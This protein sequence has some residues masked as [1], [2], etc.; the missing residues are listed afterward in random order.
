MQKIAV[1][2]ALAAN[3]LAV[4]LVF[5][6]HGETVEFELAQNTVATELAKRLPL[7]LEFSD[8][9]NKE[10]ITP[11]NE[12]LN[13]KMTAKQ[14]EIG[15]GY[16]PQIG[17]FFYFAPWGNLGIFY[18]KQPPHNGLALIGRLKNGADLKKVRQI[19]GK[20]TIKIKE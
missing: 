10:K 13:L 6:F 14:G 1:A 18:E 2:T 11:P 8:Y 15:T 3:L 7:I 20:T 12:P 17:D 5:E 19:N 16:E 9:A 4:D